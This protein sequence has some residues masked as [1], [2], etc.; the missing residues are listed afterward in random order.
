MSK[1]LLIDDLKFDLRI[2]VLVKNI[3]PLKIFI[4]EEGLARF[5]TVP[6]KA[7]NMTNI[8]DKFIHLTNYSIN[9]DNP[10]FIFNKDADEDNCGHKRS[11]TALFS[12]LE[13]KGVDIDDLWA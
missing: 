6:Y 1:P 2:Y 11:L 13:D 9:K 10:S 12:T 7:P 4:Y 5:A 8:A 3:S